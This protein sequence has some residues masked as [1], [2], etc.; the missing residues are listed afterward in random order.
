MHKD[1]VEPLSNNS[2]WYV[3]WTILLEIS[4]GALFCICMPRT[5]GLRDVYACIHISDCSTALMLYTARWYLCAHK[6]VTNCL[7][8]SYM[9]RTESLKK[10]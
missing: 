1:Y 7:Y 6:L 4:L 5:L 8:L 3:V 10:L 9:Y 2:L